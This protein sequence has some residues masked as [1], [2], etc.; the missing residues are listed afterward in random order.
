MGPSGWT[1]PPGPGAH[2]EVHATFTPTPAGVEVHGKHSPRGPHLI[3]HPSGNRAA[4]RTHLQAACPWCQSQPVQV[5]ASDGIEHDLQPGEAIARL[6]PGV[7]QEISRLVIRHAIGSTTLCRDTHRTVGAVA[8]VAGPRMVTLRVRIVARNRPDL[9]ETEAAVEAALV[10]S[11]TRS[12][13]PNLPSSTSD[14]YTKGRGDGKIRSPVGNRR[15]SSC[16]PGSRGFAGFCF[17]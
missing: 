12:P 6:G 15:S 17:G 5:A 4:A 9:G 8:S 1:P 2:L 14:P 11:D 13:T 7:R 16:S 3:R 10:E